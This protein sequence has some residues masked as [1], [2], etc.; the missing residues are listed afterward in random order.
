[1]G[2]GGGEVVI[3]SCLKTLLLP[4]LT[5]SS[6]SFQ[7]HSAP[8]LASFCEGFFLKHM[9]TLLEQE[10]FKQLIYGRNSKV[11]GLDPLQDLQATLASRLHSVYITSRV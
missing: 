10:P 1:M 8:Q 7:I 2:G 4:G 11:Q 9:S 3:D 6:C 5:K